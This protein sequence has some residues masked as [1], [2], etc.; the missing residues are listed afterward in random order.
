MGAFGCA[1]AGQFRW[2]L[3]SEPLV[4]SDARLWCIAHKYRSADP[5]VSPR[6]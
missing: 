3:A 6:V 5:A 4:A 2:Y 1:V